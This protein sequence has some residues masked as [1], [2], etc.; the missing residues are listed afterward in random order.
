MRMET[1]YSKHIFIAFFVTILFLS[2]LIVK[3]LVP[4][5]LWSAVLSFIFYPVHAWINKR[6]NRPSLSAFTTILLMILFVTVPFV[7]VLQSVS[8]E[9][10]GLYGFAR[11]HLQDGNLDLDSLDAQCVDNPALKCRAFELYGRT[12]RSL[13]LDDEQAL[14]NFLRPVLNFAGSV[15]LGIPSIVFRIAI[16]FF[17]TFFLLRDGKAFIRKTFYYLPLKKSDSD[18]IIQQLHKATYSI[19]FASLLVAL[20]QGMLGSLGFWVAGFDSPIILGL[21]MAFFAL[22]PMVGTAIVWGPASLYLVGKGLFSG[23]TSEVWWGVGLFLYGM[24]VIS[25]L[26]NFLRPKIAG[27]VSKIHPLVVVVGVIGGTS[28]WGFIGIFVGPVIL[29][30]LITFIK[31]SKEKFQPKLR[32]V[33]V[34]N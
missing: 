23:M 6:L 7:F 20:I 14:N 24:F 34:R 8:N 2:F 27:D 25:T 17:I 10:F 21:I 15:A 22:I 19:V 4:I 11:E 29:A 28:L 13:N 18:E 32:R 26:D 33:K 12:A 5:L 1:N 16:A 31:L 9:V 30:L 3:P